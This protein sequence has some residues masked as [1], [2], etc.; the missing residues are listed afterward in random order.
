M[1]RTKIMLV[2]AVAVAGWLHPGAAEATSLTA[3]T[4]EQMTDASDLIAHGVVTEVWVEKDDRGNLWTRANV[5]LTR[6]LK[7]DATVDAVTIDQMGG[8]LHDEF[9]FIESVP[10][11]S[12]GEQG[13]FFLEHLDSGRTS[14][15][16]WSQGKYTHRIDPDSGEPMAVRYPAPLQRNYD[17]RF[18]PH[19]APEDRVYMADLEDRI[20]SR[21]E[22]GWDG[23]PIP[24][25]DPAKLSRINKLQVGVTP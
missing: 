15:V 20:L 7:G 2:A 19:P 9:Q 8:V 17:H 6:T 23:Q 4:V 24:G 11:F 22:Q 1:T 18:I 13:L 16:G 25:A 12:Q 10:R 5:E 14:V 3:L 21:V